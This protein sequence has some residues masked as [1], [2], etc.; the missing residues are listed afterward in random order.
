MWHQPLV[1]LEQQQLLIVQQ[2]QALLHRQHP[3]LATEQP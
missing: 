2:L 1:A 3:M